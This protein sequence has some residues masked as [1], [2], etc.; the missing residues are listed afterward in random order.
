MG[1]DF[2]SRFVKLVYPRRGG[3][4]GRRK[5]DSLVFYRDYLVREGQ[6]L[7]INWERL[8]LA[9]PEALIVTGYGKDLLKGHFP[10]IT[11]IRAHFLG[12]RFQTGLEQFILLEMGGQDTKVLYIQEGKVFDFLTNDRCAA[13]TGRYLENMARFLKMPWR[14]F[15][16]AWQEPVDISQTC[17]IFGE[18]ELIGHLLEGVPVTS[19]AAGVNASVARRAL[20]MVRR[21]P[22]RN[23]VF[24]GGV[25]LNRAVVR[26]LK[27]WG[28]FRVWVPSF[29]Q[30][31]GALGCCLEALNL[32]KSPRP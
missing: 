17:A 22:C 10:T 12:A 28:N 27:E 6:G 31:N 32:L 3:S 23:L 5:L 19:L 11:E 26:L 18:S 20:A 21:Y 2:G 15:G 9:P 30:S 29:P 8:R 24:V 14:E 1:L 13:G 16:A 4:W 25:A 7:F